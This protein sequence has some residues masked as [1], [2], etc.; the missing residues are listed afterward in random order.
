MHTIKRL[1]ALQE[2]AE[3]DPQEDTVNRG[4]LSPLQS[5]LSPSDWRATVSPSRL[6][7]L[8]DGWMRPTTPSSPTRAS[9]IFAPDK[10]SVSEPV[11]VEHGTGTAPTSIADDDAGSDDLDLEDFERMVV[12]IVCH[13]PS[14]PSLSRSL[15]RVGSQRSPAC[16][17]V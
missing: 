5:P 12:R 6:S 17:H 10:K 3:D 16:R 1:A 15:A 7:N 11:L 9:V 14:L 8:F 13:L 2:H 4:D